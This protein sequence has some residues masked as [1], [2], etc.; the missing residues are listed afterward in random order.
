MPCATPAAPALTQVGLS[1][2]G[3]ETW[4]QVSLRN[5]LMVQSDW[6]SWHACP[7]LPFLAGREVGA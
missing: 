4:R 7:A 1:W 6:V 5:R 3:F 2:R